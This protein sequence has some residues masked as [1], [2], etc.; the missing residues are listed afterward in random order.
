[1]A[2]SSL[3]RCKAIRVGGCYESSRTLRRSHWDS[4][5]LCVTLRHSDNVEL[6][7]CHMR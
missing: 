5:S 7:K 2:T 1:L 3:I 6:G 4:D